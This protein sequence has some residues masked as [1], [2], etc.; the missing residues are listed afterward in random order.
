MFKYDDPKD[1]PY[2]VSESSQILI[3]LVL[4]TLQFP[5]SLMDSLFD[6]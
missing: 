6:L 5:Q 2:Q 3:H 4:E 1:V